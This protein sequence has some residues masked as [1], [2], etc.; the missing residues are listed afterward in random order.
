MSK[1]AAELTS[2][3]E[4]FLACSLGESEHHFLVFQRVQE[5]DVVLIINDDH[6]EDGP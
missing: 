1:A 5:G 6:G 2:F 3:D 4:Y